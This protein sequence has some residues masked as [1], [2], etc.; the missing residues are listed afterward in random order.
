MS[1]RQYS[2][3]QCPKI[4]EKKTKKLLY[5]TVLCVCVLIVQGFK[6]GEASQCGNASVHGLSGDILEHSY[7]LLAENM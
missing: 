3:I 6:C 1:N 4:K 5:S 7:V 2:F